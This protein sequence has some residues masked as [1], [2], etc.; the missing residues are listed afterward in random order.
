VHGDA[1]LHRSTEVKTA[2]TAV[3]ARLT[4]PVVCLLCALAVVP[5]ADGA[6]PG[7]TEQL[8]GAI[9]RVLQV[10]EDPALKGEARAADRHRAVRQIADEIF[11]FE[12]TARRAMAQH[13]RSLTPAQRTEFVDVFSDLLERAYMSKIELYSGEKIQYPGERVE[14]DVATVSSRII[15]KKGTEVPIDYRMLR[16]ADRWRIYD[17]SIEGVSLV[18][19]YRTQFNSIIRTSSYDEL[20]GKMRSRVEEIRQ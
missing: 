11:D 13:W 5:A 6:G 17:V 18:A 4:L 16:R 14:D 15:T 19:N 2:R 9:D 7:P 20:L 12:E 10:L 1:G 8:R 3:S